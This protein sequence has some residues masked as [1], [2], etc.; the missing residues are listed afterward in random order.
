MEWELVVPGRDGVRAVVVRA[1]EKAT[2]ADLHRALGVRSDGPDDIPL[3][4]AGLADGSVLGGVPPHRTGGDA[5]SEVA[6]VGGVL[7]GTTAPVRPGV[8]VVI[9]RG[10]V[11]DLVLPDNEV[12]RAH[13]KVE[14]GRVVDTGSRNGV[15][16]GAWRITAAEDLA[17]GSVFA[18]GESVLALRAVPPADAEITAEPTGGA[19][20]VNRPPRITAP[21]RLPELA[22]PAEPA[23]PRGFRFPWSATLLPLVVCGGL[24]ALLPG[25]GAYLV[26][27]AGLSPLM[28]LANLVSDRR[29]GR[30][31]HVRLHAQYERDRARFDREVLAAVTSEEHRERAADP[32][33]SALVRVAGVGRR[34]PTA[35]L[36]QRRR[37]DSDFLSL[38]VGLVDRP[39]AVVL[40]P[41]RD[42]EVPEVPVARDVPISVDL[43]GAGVLGVC[44]P[45]DAVRAVA[46]ALVAHAAVLH[47]PGD[48]G[49]VVITGRDRAADWEW[50]TW[51]PHT[52][53]SSSAFDCRRMVATDAEQ[54]EARVAELSRLVDERTAEHRRVLGD[55]PPKGRAVLVVLDGARRLRDLGGVADLLTRGPAAGVHALCLDAEENS[56]PDEC[57]ATVVIGGSG[58]RA[59]VSRPGLDVVADVLVDGLLPDVAADL[60]RALAPLR[61]LGDR[62]GDSSLP[63]RARFTDVAD[64]PLTGDPVL[65]ARLVAARWDRSPD[66]RST[67]ALLGVGPSGPITADLR[68]D[69]PH[70]LVAGTSGAGKSELLQTL[71]ASLASVNRPDAMNFVLVDYKG[72]SAFAACADLPHCVGLV[73]DL[74]GH[75]VTRVL[76]SLSAELRRRETVLAG[77]GAK[78]IEDHWARTGDRLPR[79]VIVVDEFASLVEEVPEFVPGVVGVGMRGRSLGVHVVLATQRPAGVVTA[80]LRANVNLR[81]SLRVTSDAESVD[82][83]DSADAA[84]IP[85]RLPG[86]AYLRTGHGELTAFQTARVA[87]PAESAEDDSAEVEVSPR[88]VEVLGRALRRDRDAEGT[89]TRTDLTALVAAVR[90]AA[91]GADRPHCPWLPPLPD[92]VLLDLLPPAERCGLATARVGLIDRPSAQAQD[93]FVLD[94]DA[95]PVAIAGALRSGRSTALRVLAAALVVDRSPEDLHLYG[96]DCG[97]GALD[98]VAELPHCGAI[99]D[100]GDHARVERLLGWLLE[101]VDRRERIFA[102]GRHS[103]LAEQRAAAAPQDRLPHLVLLVDRLEVFAAGYA[104]L[105]GGVLFDALLRL[106]RGG[107]AVGVTPVVATDRTGFSHRV[108]ATIGARLVMRQADR[109]DVAAFGL[110]PRTFPAH[111]P[112]GRA[113]WSET[114]EEVQFALLAPDP[115]GTAQAE[116]LHRTGVA[117][118]ARW[119]GVAPHR[120]PHR[121]DVLPATASARQVEALRTA[122]RPA[123]PA[124]CTPAVGGDHLAPVDVD[125]AQ[126][127]GTFL[128]AGPPRSG[129]STALLTIT[130]SLDGTLPVLVLAPRP[131]PL[132]VLAGRPGIEVVT[133]EK[134]M[135][136]R[137]E[138]HA[139]SGPCAVV[140]DDGERLVDFA[141]TEV[142]ESFAR[143]VG[144]SGSVLITAAT[145]ADVLAGFRYRGWLC[146]IRRSRTGLLLT[147]STED[148]ELF[149][150]RL[151]RSTPGG[152]TPGRALF[153]REGGTRRVQVAVSEFGESPR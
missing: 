106:L 48:L 34:A 23:P 74:D 4:S 82:V 14:D 90:R 149:E 107:P 32:D 102:A 44:G 133:D 49:I 116:A 16:L 126:V 68:A 148:G 3:I 37:R 9:G 104:D 130:A 85:A 61:L 83:V 80:D 52:A 142:L 123:G 132:R 99:V 111:V 59:R 36:W 131:S 30:R 20:L 64:L 140:V 93:A 47:A 105:D 143:G 76:D 151:P 40:R 118:R 11:G 75:L 2:L 128:V 100:G 24:Y 10:A 51:L 71:V 73:T 22:V 55:G 125:L 42:A 81:I 147:P 21:T 72:G 114:G 127:G 19:R 108:S 145:G 60:G 45:A 62:G 15:R 96:L 144:D 87:W 67:T 69:G 6:V 138:D 46:R 122:P 5:A 79:L 103:G 97:N 113:V 7:G 28:A 109:D 91:E 129:R 124:V 117:L 38:R 56:L 54:A 26:V 39:A 17:E 94:L 1:G 98:P 27:I 115:A 95:G 135:A 63:D 65:D 120:L 35:A 112:P 141:L 119:D 29:S 139:A 58:T 78:D 43:T 121:I 57:G 110:N 152:W 101:E 137:V 33:P 92:V 12:S 146:S 134:A 53:P 50:A 84:R 70:A 41:E 18:V 77:S 31:D 25:A 66:G 153:V 88:T 13:A 136:A 150:L 8:P 86:R 89:S